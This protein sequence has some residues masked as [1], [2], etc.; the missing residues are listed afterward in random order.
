VTTR[1]S[2]GGPA[3]RPSADFG[4]DP[5]KQLSGFVGISRVMSGPSLCTGCVSAAGS[6]RRCRAHSPSKRDIGNRDRGQISISSPAPAPCGRAARSATCGHHPS[7]VP[8]VYRLLVHDRGLGSGRY[9][10]WLKE[11]LIDQLLPPPS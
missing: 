9:E 7:H 1:P 8:G 11:I 4:S 10:R 2:A 6:D 3:T 5:R